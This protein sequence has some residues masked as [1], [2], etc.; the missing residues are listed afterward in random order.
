MAPPT[1]AAVKVQPPPAPEQAKQQPREFSLW[2]QA[3]EA[4]LL[5]AGGMQLGRRQGRQ[6][7]VAAAALPLGSSRLPAT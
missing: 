1:A 6:A 2:K 5:E 4:E 3:S 7:R